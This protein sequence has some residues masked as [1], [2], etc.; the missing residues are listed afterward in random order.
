MAKASRL[1]WIQTVTA[2]CEA[3]LASPHVRHDITIC[4]ARGAH[5]VQMPENI[6]GALFHITKPYLTAALNQRDSRWVRRIGTP[7]AGQTL[8][9]LGLG[10]IGQELARKAAALEMRVIGTKRTPTPLPNIA[11]VYPQEATDE[12][13]GAADFVLL[14]LPLTADTENFINARRLA[15]M[16]STAWLL[17]FARGG[18]IVD[19]DLIAAVKAKK[20]AGAIL[21]VFRE[22]PLPSAHPFWQTEGIL[23]LPHIGG[24]H[25][26]RSLGVAEVFVEN[27]RLSLEGRPLA[28]VVDRARG[29]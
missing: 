6:L 14:L 15:A 10:E 24:G 21:D 23:V 27:L 26:Q 7:L 12:V 3:W 25:P 17:N 16:K 1:T 2:G 4:C 29:Y 22:E 13:L 5:R 28:T 11:K 19:A 18:L 20:I 9:I 8:G